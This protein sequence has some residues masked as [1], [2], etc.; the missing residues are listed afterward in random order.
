MTQNDIEDPTLKTLLI[1]NISDDLKV[2]TNTISTIN[3]NDFLNDSL[4]S[5]TIVQAVPQEVRS[6]PSV[7]L[8][9]TTRRK[10]KTKP[11]TPKTNTNSNETESKE[12]QNDK[13]TKEIKNNEESE[14]VQNNEENQNETNEKIDSNRNEY[15]EEEED[16]DEFDGE[17]HITGTWENL[18]ISEFEKFATIHPAFIVKPEKLRKHT[19]KYA[20]EMI[21]EISL[22]QPSLIIGFPITTIKRDLLQTTLNS[23]LQN[24]V[25]HKCSQKMYATY[26]STKNYS[27]W[28]DTRTFK[29]AL[30]FHMKCQQL[31]SIRNAL[32]MELN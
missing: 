15:N 19:M 13:E 2:I 24:A 9:V 22:D 31:N 21:K 1:K 27:K 29:N 12:T 30:Y 17:V 26:R 25:F 32:K 18:Y 14:K 7:S 5:G 4:P 16:N 10:N 11:E 28:D 8:F 23:L 6:R 3:K 20:D